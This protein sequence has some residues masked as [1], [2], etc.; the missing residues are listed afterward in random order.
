MVRTIIKSTAKYLPERVVT[1]K[2]LEKFMDTSDD[3]IYKRTGIK[4]RRWIPEGSSLRT[5]DLALFAS[6]KALEKAGWKANDLDCIILATQTSDVYI[7]GAAP[8]LQWKLGLETT[9]CIDIRQ[10]CAG[11]LYGLPIADSFIKSGLYSKILLTC[12][13]VQS[14]GIDISTQGRD[15]SVLFADGAGSVCL[16]AVETDNDIG[17]ISSVLH[18]QGEHYKNIILDLSVGYKEEWIKKGKH[19]PQMNGRAVFIHAVKRLPEVAKEVLEKA[20][21][22]INEIDMFIFHQANKRINDLVGKKIEIPP[23]KMFDNIKLYGNT[24]AA[25]IP[26][27][28]DEALDRYPN[29]KTIMFLGYGAGEN[30]GAIIYKREEISK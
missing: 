13:E 2:E 7:P 9:P 23:E 22:S 1:N 21:M 25:T 4:E 5:S 27:A 17:V 26:I 11:F 28:L 6:E 12:A 20:N 19:W 18:T 14:L 8:I 29:T 30:W 24:T 3:W 10:Q 16:E 15:M